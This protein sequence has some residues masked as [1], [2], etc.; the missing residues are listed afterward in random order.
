VVLGERLI[1]IAIGG[2]RFGRP[3]N[4][5]ARRFIDSF[6]ITEAKPARGW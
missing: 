2:G 4:T 3:N 5:N 6:Q 1:S